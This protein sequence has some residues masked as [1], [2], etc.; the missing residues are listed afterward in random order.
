MS[1]RRCPHYVRHGQVVQQSNK[2]D[3]ED[4]CGL[5]MKAGKGKNCEEY[6]F[7]AFF[8]YSTCSVYRDTF[9]GNGQRNDVVPMRDLHYG[10]AI[11]SAGSITDMELL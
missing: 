11:S 4:N 10:D 1:C 6:P 5:K 3:F 7:G 2:I 8:D 9:K